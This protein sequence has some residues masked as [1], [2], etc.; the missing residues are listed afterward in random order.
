MM[1]KKEHLTKQGLDLIIKIK[2]LMANGLNN[3]VKDLWPELKDK[4]LLDKFDLAFKITSIPSPGANSRICSGRGFIF[5]F[6]L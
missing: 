2:S 1:D 6:T 4:V 3:K 5:S